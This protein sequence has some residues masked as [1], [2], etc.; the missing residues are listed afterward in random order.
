MYM[1]IRI[2]IYIY[3]YVYMYIFVYIYIYIYIYT[4]IYVCIYICIYIYILLSEKTKKERFRNTERENKST[5]FSRPM[6]IFDLLLFDF[7]LP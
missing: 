6:Y 5:C 4:Y 1:Y 7:F 3:I 2:Y